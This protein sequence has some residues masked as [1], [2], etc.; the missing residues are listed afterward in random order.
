MS[1][2]L[3]NRDTL[4]LLFNTFT[5]QEMIEVNQNLNTSWHFLSIPT[6][7]ILTAS[8]DNQ[9]C[10]ER[11][12]EKKCLPLI[13]FYLAEEALQKEMFLSPEL[14]ATL[15]ISLPSVE[16]MVFKGQI[17]SAQ[18]NFQQTNQTTN[19]PSLT[20]RDESEKKYLNYFYYLRAGELFIVADDGTVQSDMLL[21]SELSPLQQL[22]AQK[23][24]T[25]SCG[26][27]E[28]MAEQSV[29]A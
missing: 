22:Q 3:K 5:L 13:R 27:S 19:N 18:A 4:T 29:S 20:L 7:K 16:A 2:L 15:F 17:V 21:Y 9:V 23:Y 26:S 8:N 14:L 6:E 11:F 28:T 1:I 10:I 25:L 24:F 12:L